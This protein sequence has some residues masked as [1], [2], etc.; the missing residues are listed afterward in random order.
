MIYR[1]LRLLSITVIFINVTNFPQEYEK[2][3]LKKKYTF[4]GHSKIKPS[5]ATIQIS[6]F[7]SW[8]KPACKNRK[9][10]LK[11]ILTEINAPSE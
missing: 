6:I 9:V 4:Y 1:L 8:I 7:S 5:E 2:F 11:W 3:Q 10:H